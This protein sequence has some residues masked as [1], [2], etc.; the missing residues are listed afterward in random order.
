M[1]ND[2]EKQE[3]GPYGQYEEVN[4]TFPATAGT[5]LIVRHSL[6]PYTPEHID[7]EI[8][9]QN[10]PAIV[11]QD[12]AATRTP[13]QDGYIVVRCNMANAKVTLRL[14]VRHRQQTLDLNPVEIPV[15]LPETSGLL[16]QDIHLDTIDQTVERG[17]MIVGNATPKWTK[18]VPSATGQVLKFDGNDLIFSTNGAELTGLNAS[19]ISAGTLADARLSSNIPLKDTNASIT[20]TYYFNT[21]PVFNTLAIP[22]AALKDDGL[23]ARLAAAETVAGGWTFTPYIAFTAGLKERG[24]TTGLGEWI[25]E[26]FDSAD[27]TAATGSWTVDSGDQVTLAYTLIGKTMILAF[28]LQ[29][30]DVSSAT[31][32]LRM[33]IPGGFTAATQTVGSIFYRDAGT[34]GTGIAYVT[35]A[36]TYVTFRRFSTSLGNWTSTAADNTDIRGL[37]I[38]E[39]Q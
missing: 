9:R 24:R 27:F 12:G 14:S 36:G 22:E 8:V 11:Y 5:D 31:S 13:W 34:T 10:Q 2:Q 20:G 23:L 32:E 6:K 19:N 18:L 15:V 33:A 37:L 3:L 7:Y 30:T 39:V 16:D 26:A 4:V 38:F 21:D 28:D 35:A 25:D 17:A 1:I 29:G